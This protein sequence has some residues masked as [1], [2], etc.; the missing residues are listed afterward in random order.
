MSDIHARAPR[1]RPAHRCTLRLLAVAIAAITTTGAMAEAIQETLVTGQRQAYRGDVPLDETPKAI[2]ILDADLLQR[3]GVTVLAEALDLSA[4]MARQNNFGGLW[5]N[6]ATRGFAGDENLP[7]GYLVNGFNAG[8]GFGGPRDVSGI[9]RVEILRGPNAAL[10]GRGE[11]GGSVNLVTKQPS[12]TPSADIG[13]SFGSFETRRFDADA[14]TGLGDAVA[15]RVNGFHERSDG[16]RDTLETERY[17]IM[18]SLLYRIGE[19]T[20][21]TYEL[22]FTRQ[23]IPFDRGVVAV[24]GRLGA[25]PIE[26]FLG[27]PGDG[28]MQA[29]ATG[30]QL[31]LQ[32]D[33]GADWS[34]LLGATWRETEL[35]GFSTEAELATNRQPFFTN[36][37]TLARQRR[38]RDYESEHGVIRAEVSGRFETGALEH[39]LI[40]GADVDT[41]DNGQLFLRARPPTIASN[42]TQAAAN[43][44]DVLAPEYGRFPLPTPGPQTNRLDEQRAYG[45]YVQD[46][47]SIG[48]RWH[49]RLG[50]RWDDYGQDSTNRNNGATTHTSDTRFSPQAG[51][52]YEVDDGFSVY[53]AWGEGFRA[54]SG[55]DAAGNAFSPEESSSIEVG[56]R[57]ALLDGALDMTLALF[58]MEKENILTAD[59]ANAGFSITIGEAES[60]GVEFDVTGTLPGDVQ[61]LL[62]YAWVDAEATQDVLD[63]NF[64]LVIDEGD[65]LINVPEHTLSLQLAREFA[66]GGGALTVGAGVRYVDERLGE[67]ATDFT[68][69]DYT[70]ARAF[71]AWR[72]DERFE[73]RAE[74]DNLFDET[75]YTNSFSRLWVAPGA[76]RNATVS[77]RYRY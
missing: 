11:P 24:D 76:D 55:A 59:P 10:F 2:T 38:F 52:V 7:S 16:F 68:L 77:L 67:T 21:L 14:T 44:I 40:A 62:S 61:L 35:E 43:I 27:E 66:L 71:A 12:F 74:V 54:N 36:G 28:P 4:T 49:V 20:S 75:Y 13:A 32:H 31:Q 39:R 47:V 30:H 45:I 9:E 58:R 72:L 34:L 42:P 3:T 56:A 25:V 33:F 23:E 65:A 6:F 29:D 19:R 18:P 1:L 22:E 63:F 8:R 15:V 41:F 64:A 48:E 5:D 53:A 26:R 17:G 60:R 73:V 70:V 50:G 57:L 37:R 69:P 46:H 51:V